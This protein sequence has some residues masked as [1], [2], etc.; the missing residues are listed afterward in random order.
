MILSRGREAYRGQASEA[1][2]Y[3]ASIGHPMP[4]QT[5]PA[6][7]FLDLV[8]SDFASDEDV[9]RILAAWEE[10]SGKDAAGTGAAVTES[11]GSV[12][13]QDDQGADLCAQFVT[14]LRRHAYLAYKD[15]VP[16]IGRSIIFLIGNLYFSAVYIR[17][18]NRNQDQVLNRFWII[19]WYLCVPTQI[20]VVAVYTYNSEFNSIKKEI[21]NGMVSPA[22]YLLA[23]GMLEIPIMYIFTLFAIGI[24]AYAIM[25]FDAGN[26]GLYSLMFALQM[27]IWEAM[28][29]LF[30]VQ[31][32]NPLIGMMQV[33]NMWFSGFLFAG[34]LIPE[35]DMVYPFKIFYWILPVRWQLPL[36]RVVHESL[37]G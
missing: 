9:E 26:F 37:K 1:V 3:F 12:R 27:Y 35:D 4:D 31:F 13:S 15:P 33:M 32:P 16:Y 19:V 7:F 30:S 5:N 2:S 10:H 18:R 28:A 6:E 21:K 34:F 22:T 17:A 20:A 14:M 36:G 11:R 23:K 24:P 8:N 29:E 25:D